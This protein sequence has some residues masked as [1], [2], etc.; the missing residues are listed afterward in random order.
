MW[1]EGLSVTAPPWPWRLVRFYMSEIL[2]GLEY[3]HSQA[4][5]LWAGFTLLR[6]RRIC[7]CWVAK[8]HDNHTTHKWN[9][10][11]HLYVSLSIYLCY[12]CWCLDNCILHDTSWCPPFSSWGCFKKSSHQH[13]D[14]RHSPFLHVFSTKSIHARPPQQLLPVAC[15][16]QGILYRDLKPE[17]CLLDSGGRETKNTPK[18]GSLSTVDGS[19]ILQTSWYGTY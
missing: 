9:N 17:N 12:V 15:G 10:P 3:L 2:L 8:S 4:R 14:A 1:V 11:E 13:V 6:A 18:P 16:F 5:P 19:Q 7:W